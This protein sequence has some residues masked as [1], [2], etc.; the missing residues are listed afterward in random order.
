[1]TDDFKKVIK[2]IPKAL[3]I[4]LVMVPVGLAVLTIIEAIILVCVV[5]FIPTFGHSWRIVRH[6]KLTSFFDVKYVQ[7]QNEL[8]EVAK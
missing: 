7:K 4:F 1:M 3:G 6:F 5:L 8:G 2:N